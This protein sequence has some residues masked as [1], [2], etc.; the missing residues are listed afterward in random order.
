MKAKF[1]LFITITILMASCEKVITI[2]QNEFKPKIV[3]NAVLNANELILISLSES[4]DM[5]YEGN[6]FPALKNA[7]AEIFEEGISIGKLTEGQNGDYHINYKPVAGKTYH[8]NVSHAKF[9]S[10][11]ATTKIPF[12]IILNEVVIDKISDSK[13][14]VYFDI[15]DIPDD[16]FYGIQILREDS[17]IGIQPDT[18]NN[19]Y[20]Y[21]KEY[22][23]CTDLVIEYPKNESLDGDNINDIFLFKDQIF[24]NSKYKLRCSFE[25]N[26]WQGDHIVKLTASVNSYSYEYYR[27]IITTE[28]F[29]DNG[30][31]PFA[32]PVQIFNN[33]EN[34]F[35]IFGAIATK[36]HTELL[37]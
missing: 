12:P 32:E 2:D 27:Y 15:N 16:N 24:K 21:D 34:G 9:E 20:N 22:F 36:S 30:G 37:E 3:L 25:K 13:H 18:T 6:E 5:L 17:L 11:N 14:Y 1:S 26:T 7:T 19:Y 29:S 33:I 23:S 31:N 4:R 35:G 8:I 28:I 10:V